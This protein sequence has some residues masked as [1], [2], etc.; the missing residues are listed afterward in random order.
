[1]LRLVSI[2]EVRERKEDAGCLNHAPPGVLLSCT[3]TAL[4]TYPNARTTNRRENVWFY[5]PIYYSRSIGAMSTGSC[6]ETFPTILAEP[7]EYV[8][9]RCQVAFNCN[10]CAGKYT[11]QAQANTLYSFAS[12]AFWSEK[13]ENMQADVQSIQ[14]THHI[15]CPLCHTPL[16]TR[17]SN[18]AIG[19]TSETSS[20]YVFCSSCGYTAPLM[21]RQHAQPPQPRH[22]AP[23]SSVWIDPTVSTYL[24]GEQPGQPVSGHDQLMAG[25]DK[26]GL[27]T[28][29]E[30]KTPIPPR[31]SAQRL[32]AV[33]V[34]PRYSYTRPPE[35]D[36]SDL[37]RIPTLAPP[38]TWQ[39]E[40]QDFTAE[41]SLSSLSLIVDAPTH[42][43]AEIP[44]TR[45][46]P[47]PGTLRIE[48]MNTHPSVIARDP[49]ESTSDVAQRAIEEHD[50]APMQLSPV[51]A[52]RPNG[53]GSVGGSPLPSAASLFLGDAIA[54]VSANNLSSRALAPI[55]PAALPV[56]MEP[57]NGQIASAEPASW[58]AGAGAGSRY[59]QLVAARTGNPGRHRHMLSFNIFD[60][61]RWWLLHPGRFEFLLWL[62]GTLLLMTVTCIFFL[63]TVL[64][65]QWNVADSHNGVSS[66]A[67]GSQSPANGQ[68]VPADV[69]LVLTNT[70]SLLAGQPLHLRGL[71]FSANSHIALTYDANQPFLNQSRQ[72]VLAQTDAHG[73][74]AVTLNSPSW[75]AGQHRIT[76]RDLATG[77]RKTVLIT[78]A[79]AITT[80]TTATPVAAT[81]VATAPTTQQGSNTPP[82]TNTPT[83][84]PPTA[85]PKLPTPTPTRGITPTATVGIT[86]TP[87]ASVTPKVNGSATAGVNETP[88]VSDTATA[89]A[90]LS[91]TVNS[92]ATVGNAN[93]ATISSQDIATSGET[94]ITASPWLWLLIGGY[95][96][97]MLLFGLAGL[98]RKRS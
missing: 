70:G 93:P 49:I 76:A 63:M 31:A 21:P 66:S 80:P 98:S 12:R 81:P 33:R 74:F 5:P 56:V 57:Q 11:D 13:N 47:P 72:P 62:G 4:T 17:T 91:P 65:V 64:S 96:L 79:D 38:A 60:R 59:A 94:N 19:I 22:Q 1:M 48:E 14:S 39:Y 52:N 6:C 30:P 16:A 29:G 42:P 18:D 83:V 86:A 75:K 58:T 15:Y 45:N 78:V 51:R 27:Y 68:T 2:C 82:I 77:Y 92:T 89:G 85:T 87:G 24:Q 90:S 46:T 10:R 36:E 69:S 44:G 73:T 53:A 61:M 32:H 28:Q 3:L 95:A 7:P 40:S 50:T 84:V 25:R 8:Q 9:K 41:S 35:S 43:Q 97:A 71:G 88:T 23:K 20:S 34:R 54:P 55:V 26:S 67:N 37:T